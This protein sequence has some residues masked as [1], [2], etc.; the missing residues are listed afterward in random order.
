MILTLVWTRAHTDYLRLERKFEL[1][2]LPQAMGK[3]R[4]RYEVCFHSLGKAPWQ[5]LSDLIFYFDSLSYEG[6]QAS[7]IRSTPGISFALCCLAF[8]Y[9]LRDAVWGNISILC[10]LKDGF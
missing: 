7:T 3:I 2:G 1:G 8:I 9:F 10:I 5:K 6:M 4:V